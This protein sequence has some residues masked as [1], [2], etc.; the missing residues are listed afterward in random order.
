M[1]CPYCQSPIEPSASSDGPTICKSCG[2]TISAEAA[3]AKAPAARRSRG[4]LATILLST[5]FLVLATLAVA[6]TFVAKRTLEE[7]D[8]VREDYLQASA[9]LEQCIAAVATSGPLKGAAAEP[10]RK[11]IL[12]PALAYY[13]HYV[14]E[15]ATDKKA[16][17]HKAA[18]YL[19]MSTIQAKL[20]SKESIPSLRQGIGFV[21]ELTKEP[22]VDPASFP[23]VQASVLK[24][25]SQGDW[26]AV[27]G[28]S[29]QEMQGLGLGLLL[30]A[31]FAAPSLEDMAKNHPDVVSFRDDVAGLEKML[32]SIFPLV[33]QRDRALASWLKARDMLE[34]LVRDR[35][36]DAE[37]K[38]RL[39]ESLIEAA[40]LQKSAKQ[41]DE[42][43]ANY[44]RA[45]E[46]REQLAAAKP[47]DKT[48]QQALVAVKRD[49]DKLKPAQASNDA[50]AAPPAAPPAAAK[51]KGLELFK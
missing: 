44:Q 30:S 32:A 35:P 31:Q 48:L 5:V 33:G 15:H 1:Q 16:L 26:L 43:A 49:L 29:S 39:A 4:W 22:N 11:E 13:Q 19:H 3:A 6:S 20:G 36:A 21:I 2:A 45:V 38:T 40:K 8:R 23:S 7:R 9:A 28:V 18:A 14:Q 17:A 50:A 42:A 10:A 25:V 34:T 12:E 47:D 27:K 41:L 24:L 51:E 37:Y 46:V